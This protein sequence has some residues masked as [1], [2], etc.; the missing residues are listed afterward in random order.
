[1]TSI[2]PVLALIAAFGLTG[3]AEP[4]VDYY[5]GYVEVEYLHLA[6]PQSGRIEQLTVQ[7][8]DRVEADSLLLALEATREQAAL[9][10]TSSRLLQTQAQ[11]QDL[12]TGLRAEERAVIQAQ[13]AQA[14]SAAELSAR[15]AE[16]RR[17][18]VHRKLLAAEEADAAQTLAQRDAQRVNE[19]RA[20][21]K[22]AALPARQAQI[23]AAQAAVLS[24]EAAQQQAQ[25]TLDQ[26]RLDSPA[27]GWL[28]EVYFHRGE[29]APGGAPLLAIA[30]EDRFEV[31]FF[32]P[33]AIAGR[34]VAGQTVQ[35]TGPGLPRPLEAQV[36]AVADQAEY[37]P[38]LIFSRD[39]NEKLLFQI[40][41]R[42]DNRVD[43]ER[44]RLNPGLPVEVRLP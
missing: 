28:H 43:G 35:I 42:I 11:W 31:R 41:A 40:R 12:G 18:L 7:R 6:L 36:T 10:E 15:E 2:R 13:L 38:P 20:Q 29:W 37:A 32:V 4:E 17:T 27:A 25:W 5:Q 24:A 33:T 14:R 9:A 23:D 39:R 22:V 30:P 8:G 19:L 44:L 21:L 3:C 1:M 16:R 34:L 26:R